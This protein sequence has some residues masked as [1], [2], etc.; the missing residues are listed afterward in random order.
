MCMDEVNVDPGAMTELRRTLFSG[1]LYHSGS[2]DSWCN[3]VAGV[4]P[5]SN[6]VPYLEQLHLVFPHRPA[7]PR[8]CARRSHF[9]RSRLLEL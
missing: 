7:C 6:I 1:H 8:R 5:K 9:R 2:G 3:I 4:S